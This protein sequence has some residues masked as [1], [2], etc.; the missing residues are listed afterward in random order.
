[1]RLDE[2]EEAVARGKQ[3]RATAFIVVTCRQLLTLSGPSRSRVGSELQELGLLR[4]SAMYIKNGHMAAI[5]PYRELRPLL[6]PDVEVIDAGEC[7]VLPRSID[8]HTHPVFGDNRITV[9]LHTSWRCLGGHGSSS[10][11][12][13]WPREC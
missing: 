6:S 12:E 13:R 2:A 1:V 4:D 5:G 8:A 3:S 10:T 11:A 9:S 7:A